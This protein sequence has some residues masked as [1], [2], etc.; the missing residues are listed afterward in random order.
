M[1]GLQDAVREYK[2]APPASTLP[3]PQFASTSSVR[4]EEGMHQT[5]EVVTGMSDQALS[6]QG[7]QD[8]QKTTWKNL[9]P[10]GIAIPKWTEY[11]SDCEM[12]FFLS[13]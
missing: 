4:L 2:N 11:W 5:S 3:A 10:G 12:G 7:S 13:D 1:T 8:S 6:V 9:K